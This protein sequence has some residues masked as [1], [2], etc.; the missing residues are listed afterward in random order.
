MRH[1]QSLRLIFAAALVVLVHLAASTA[2]AQ[3]GGRAGAY[4]RMGFGA[5]GL[6]MGNAMTAVTTGDAVGYYNPASL[7]YAQYRNVA[8]S[9]GILSLD[10]RL[11]FL[12]FVQP[13]G[14]PNDTTG[15]RPQAGLAVG[16]INS[17][18]S[19]IDGRD[20]DGEPTGLLQTS[21]N[22]AFLSFGTAL[23]NKL[24]I[25][26][27]IKYLYHHLY[28]SVNSSTF[29]LDLG[30]LFPLSDVLTVAATARDFSSKYRWDT[31]E[32]YGQQQA[33]TT[34]DKFPRL[35]TFGAAYT[36]PDSFG[37][38]AVDVEFSDRSTVHL[39]VGAEI[40]I[41]SEVT[42]RAGMDKIDLKEKGMGV[43]P[44]FGFSVRQ[45]FASWTPAL[46]YAFV[47]EPFA[48]SALHMISLSVIF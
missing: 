24:A 23:R 17:G 31:K 30:V 22:Q 9:F 4:S 15:R 14:Q 6:G 18:V 29:G 42:L 28:T 32:V 13:L 38:A 43:R 2:H 10:R 44:S 35:Y 33:A 21:E 5:R 12:S 45:S 46:N 34:T 20:S 36:L 47:I 11:N 1:A 3:L 39:K 41:L 16:I 19:K 8:A 37:V 25:G 48:P 7:P 27:T 26:V 40:A